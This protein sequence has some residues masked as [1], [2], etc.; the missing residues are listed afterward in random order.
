MTGVGFHLVGAAAGGGATRRHATTITGPAAVRC[1]VAVKLPQ[2]GADSTSWYGFVPRGHVSAEGAPGEAWV[3]RARG[4]E[5]PGTLE[6]AQD[7]ADR[8]RGHWLRLAD[9]RFPGKPPPGRLNVPHK[10]AALPS[11]SRC[12]ARPARS[13][14]ASDGF[15][16]GHQVGR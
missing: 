2:G 14:D 13:H 8:S 1:A 5:L 4:R 6:D 15:D 3:C 12:P 7:A 9:P 11:D 10:A 16:E